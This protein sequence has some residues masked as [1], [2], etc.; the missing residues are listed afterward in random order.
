MRTLTTIALA[1][2]LVSM[3]LNALALQ[4]NITQ[5]PQTGG[6]VIDT[7][8]GYSNSLP[9]PVYQSPP[10]APCPVPPKPCS[11]SIWTRD[12]TCEQ[13][14]QPACPT[15]S[16]CGK[17]NC[18]SCNPVCQPVC[19]VQKPCGKPNC[20]VCCFPSQP[21][22][23]TPA[24]C[25][26]QPVCAPVCQPVCQ[27]PCEKKWKLGFAFD[28]EARI[29]GIVDSVSNVPPDV[30]AVPAAPQDG[31]G[32]LPPI[33]PDCVDIAPTASLFTPGIGVGYKTCDTSLMLGVRPEFVITP[34][35][36]CSSNFLNWGMDG[37]RKLQYSPNSSTFWLSEFTDW[38]VPEFLLEYK[39]DRGNKGIGLGYK[40]YHLGLKTGWEINGDCTTLQDFDLADIPTY[41]LYGK[42]NRFTLGYNFSSVNKKGLG[43]F[44]DIGQPF[45]I[46]GGYFAPL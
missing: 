12:K 21:V 14:C 5:N 38:V 33:E 4:G 18:Q 16:R 36:S 17:P 29:G 3:P 37:S 24:P 46:F 2:C 31:G 9:A 32:S 35:T 41:S 25:P 45:S 10:P 1:L 26:P 23:Q 27:D 7:T 39:W 20:P 34:H 6:N 42:Y 44:V 19:S 30:R 11:S 40:T 43:N 13:P 28:W 8:S 15:A 22:C